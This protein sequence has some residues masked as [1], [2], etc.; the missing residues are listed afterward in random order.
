MRPFRE[1]LSISPV[2]FGASLIREVPF[3]G[4]LLRSHNRIWLLVFAF[5]SRLESS[6]KFRAGG[7]G[8]PYPSSGILKIALFI[9]PKIILRG[10]NMMVL[11]P[12]IHFDSPRVIFTGMIIETNVTSCGIQYPWPLGRWGCAMNR[13]GGD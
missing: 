8:Y 10:S 3:P 7:R 6:L 11:G 12:V 2:D 1:V 5:I 4:K 13:A 9:R